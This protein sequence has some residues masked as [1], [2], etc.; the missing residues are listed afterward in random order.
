MN[1]ITDFYDS[2]DLKYPEIGIAI[3]DINRDNPG[4]VKM[5]IPILTPNMDSSREI[6]KMVYQNTSNLMNENKINI[7]IR[8]INVTNYIEIPFQKEVC[9]SNDSNR[10]IEKGSKWLVVFVGG[11]ITKPRVI[12]RYIEE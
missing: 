6:N 5:I 11:D 10:I 2:L 12:S 8:D 3:Q 9:M 4:K 7:G 1:S